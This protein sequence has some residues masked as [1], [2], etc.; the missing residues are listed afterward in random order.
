[1]RRAASPLWPGELY[2]LLAIRLSAAS[3][4]Y[5]GWL[6]LCP[7]HSPVLLLPSRSLSPACLP[8]TG[9][10]FD[11]EPGP[12]FPFALLRDRTVSLEAG[13]ELDCSRWVAALGALLEW[14]RTRTAQLREVLRYRRRV[15][16]LGCDCLLTLRVCVWCGQTSGASAFASLSAGAGSAGGA[17][18]TSALAAGSVCA[19]AASRAAA[20]SGA[21]GS[22]GAKGGSQ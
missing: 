2:P 19:G 10:S 21:T 11:A 5:S 18:S 22:A 6:R 7:L 15:F 3:C 17:G 8:L 1:M 20:S 16:I 4:P 12:C 9:Q 13:T 14:Q